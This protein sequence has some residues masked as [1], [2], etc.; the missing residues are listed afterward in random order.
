MQKLIPTLAAGLALALSACVAPSAEEAPAPPAPAQAANPVIG[1]AAMDPARSIADNIAR[2]R[3]HTTLVSALRAT[4]VSERLD[5]TGPF[6]LFAPT[7]A[8]FARLPNGTV[9]SLMV[10]SNRTLLTQ[11]LNYH[12]VPGTKTRR[13]IAADIAAGGGTAAYRTAQG[14]WIR[15]SMA[16]RTVTVADVHGN[17]SS[18][19]IADADLSNGVLHVLDGVLLPAT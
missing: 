11:M 10:P 4:G 7:D 3:D 1:G 16:G 2:S 5:E 13:Q 17:R 6:T 9:E 8:A 14:G 18:V 19:T 12:I 15:L